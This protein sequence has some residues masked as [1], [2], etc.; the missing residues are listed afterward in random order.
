MFPRFFF[1]P[2]FR[3]L[4]IY[5]WCKNFKN[6]KFFT[7]IHVRMLTAIPFWSLSESP[8][9]AKTLG[10]QMPHMTLSLC[11]CKRGLLI[12][13]N[14]SPSITGLAQARLW[15]YQC[16]N[17]QELWISQKLTFYTLFRN[18]P[19]LIS[20]KCT[21]QCEGMLAN[22]EPHMHPNNWLQVT[23]TTHT[24]PIFTGAHR[25]SQVAMRFCD[26]SL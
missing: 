20:S 25:C 8:F 9:F 7:Q 15:L 21:Q 10:R 12:T 24:H 6:S 17:H 4:G 11:F 2:I 23:N 1:P 18:C 3:P 22:V 5:P 14:H 26:F 13:Q 16:G 19:C